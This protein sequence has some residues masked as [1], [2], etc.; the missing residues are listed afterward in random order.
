MNTS[1][2]QGSCPQKSI[3]IFLVSD[4]V[5]DSNGV[6]RFIH[7]MASNARAAGVDFTVLTASPLKSESVQNII[8]IP[9]LLTMRMPYY[10]EQHLVLLPPLIRFYRLLRSRRPDII[11]ISTPGPLGFSARFLAKLLRIPVAS[12]YHTDFPAYM[13]HNSGS[14]LVGR[15]TY[16]LMR[17]FYKKMELVI[18][19]SERFLPLLQTRLGIEASKTLYLRPGTDTRRFNPSSRDTGIWQHYGIGESAI[20]LLYVGR[21]SVEKNFNFVLERFRQLRAAAECEVTLVVV[22]EGEPLKMREAYL[23]EGIVLLGRRG[24]E[25]LSR[26]YASSDIFFF[27]ST[28]ETLGQAVM[29]AL[30]SGLACMVSNRGGVLESVSDGI[31]GYATDI[32][33]LVL[34]DARLL[35]LVSDEKRR[36]T[37]GL[38]GV[39]A[40]ASRSIQK[41]FEAFIEA[42]I[43][44][45]KRD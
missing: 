16:A 43:G 11:H 38:A 27:P 2:V 39:D 10:K 3:S 25:E 1:A 36:K 7:D 20:K 29:E 24:G 8:N 18:A 45:L 40:M 41:S 5:F 19:R 21:M 14:K 26:L 4:T 23:K 22:G 9:P 15:F 37:M 6:S 44:A 28:T 32:G 42:H 34:W 35:E 17:L 30:A 31:N 33:D 13:E 12:T